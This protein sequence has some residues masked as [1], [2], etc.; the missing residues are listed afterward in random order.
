[1]SKHLTATLP[2]FQIFFPT[3]AH[4]ISNLAYLLGDRAYH[5]LK[6]GG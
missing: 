6:Q 5:V 3:L 4:H 1:M 2:V